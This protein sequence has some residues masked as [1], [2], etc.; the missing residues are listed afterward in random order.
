[1]K[2][3]SKVFK[4]ARVKLAFTPICKVSPHFGR[5]SFPVPQ[6]VGGWVGQGGWLHTEV[7]CPHEDGHPMTDS[8]VAGDQTHNHWVTSPTPQP[9]DHRATVRPG[10]P[11][12]LGSKVTSHKNI[13]GMGLCAFV[14]AGF[15]QW[16]GNSMPDCS[17]VITQLCLSRQQQAATALH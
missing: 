7:V 4:M 13:A 2:L 9:L 16:S 11:F 10:N 12:I 5:Y 15:C 8:A 14:S 6:R 1:M 3:I 17:V